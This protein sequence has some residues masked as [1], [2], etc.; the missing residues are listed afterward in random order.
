[1]HFAHIFRSGPLY[2][3]NSLGKKTRRKIVTFSVDDYGAQRTASKT[4][5]ENMER[6]GMNMHSNRFDQYDSLETEDDLTALWETLDSV[7]DSNGNPAIFTAFLCPANID[8]QMII[9]SKGEQY[10]YILLPELYKKLG[11][12][13]MMN[14]WQQ[15]LKSKLIDVQYHGREHVN[16]KTLQTLI[17]QNDQQAWCCINN[18]SWAGITNR[19]SPSISYVSA[20]QFD[21]CTEL[22]ELADIATSGLDAF[23]KIWGYK[24]VHF[25]APG[26][27]EH[28]SLDKAL[29]QKGI[30]Y[31]DT[32]ILYREHQGNGIYK[33]HFNIPFSK[34]SVGQ[35]QIVRNC[36]YEPMLPYQS[37]WQD[38]LLFQI[39]AAFNCRKPANI[40]THRVNF[41]G[42]IS[43]R[44]RN[45]H[46]KE[47]KQILHKIKCKW[48]EVE[49]MSTR[50]MADTIINF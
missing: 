20:Y 15:G 13:N 23:E 48:P 17:R 5:L 37:D 1:M 3:K 9:N 24:A 6:A 34:N 38:Y 11:Y 45:E 12:D 31:I 32:D 10:N 50:Q 2:I 47:L 28:A 27:R 14:L 35:Y 42:H 16:L 43:E 8:F 33:R 30:K 19:I 36:V 21:S 7:R 29:F 39:Q 49:F 44:N 22:S 18:E 46:L 40:S 26:A 4:A 41:A 25:T